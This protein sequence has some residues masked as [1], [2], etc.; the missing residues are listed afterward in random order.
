MMRTR[1]QTG[2]ADSETTGCIIWNIWKS[3]EILGKFF[4]SCYRI[5]VG[6]NEQFELMERA[7][8]IEEGLSSKPL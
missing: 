2:D 6:L 8:T 3:F 1:L 4:F 7:L 5:F